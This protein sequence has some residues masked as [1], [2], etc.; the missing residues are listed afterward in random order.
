MAA[1]RGR[2]ITL[3]GG[4]GAGKSTHARR[5]AAWLA[6][7]GVVV[8]LTREPG[9]SPRAEAIRELLL[10]GRAAPF[11][12]DAEALLFAVARADH[13]EETVRPALGRGEWV[14]C[15]RFMDSTRAY[16]GSAGVATELLDRLEKLA[17]GPD[18]PDLTLIFDLPAAEGLARAGARGG[19]ADRF[20][21]DSLAVHESRR[22]AF[23]A[24]AAR[25]PERCVVIDSRQDVEAVALAVQEAVRERLGG[26]LPPGRGA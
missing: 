20:E 25:E 13:M 5:L 19:P 3:E 1:P 7:R 6:E 23:L 9:G 24:I 18:R 15:D 2:F 26:S 12:L 8:R 4:E 17:V 14:I 16:Q 22:A 11:G 21:A 10:S